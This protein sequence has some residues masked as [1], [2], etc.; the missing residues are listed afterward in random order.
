MRTALDSLKWNQDDQARHLSLVTC[1]WVSLF[2]MPLTATSRLQRTARIQDVTLSEKHTR[3]EC[4]VLGTAYGTSAGAAR[5]CF[6]V[7]F[8]GVLMNLLSLA[9]AAVVS[10]LLSIGSA[11]EEAFNKL[12]GMEGTWEATIGE[13]N[14]AF[15]TKV[16][17]KLTG[18]GTTLVETQFPGEGHEMVT[19]YHM[20][21]GKLV[22]THYCAAG[23]QPKL[24][25]AAG[26]DQNKLRFDFVSGTNMKPTDSHMHTLN[27]TFD[28]KDHVISEWQSL[29]KG[30]PGF[31][32]KFDMRR[33][34]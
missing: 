2:R 30:K 22:L 19:M 24:K 7:K 31:V 25:L 10:P 15:T 11:D 18:A 23:N 21:N 1:Q 8:D 27:M 6:L 28:G 14:S 17:Y 34:K 9:F 33:T 16:V 4:A 3:I 26:R 29:D 12:K 32:A 13:G 20:D 5:Y